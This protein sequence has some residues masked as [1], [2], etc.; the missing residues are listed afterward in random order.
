M[1]SSEKKVHEKNADTVDE[2]IT[3]RA[4]PKKH[5][6]LMILV[7][8]SIQHGNDSRDNKCFSG[9]DNSVDGSKEKKVKEC[10]FSDMGTFLDK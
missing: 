2:D 7:R 8:N 5:E 1:A 6:G 9:N 4:F 10:V 3:D